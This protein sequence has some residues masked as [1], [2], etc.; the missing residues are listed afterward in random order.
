MQAYLCAFSIAVVFTV[1][2][3]LTVYNWTLFTCR[4]AIKII[5][6]SLFIIVIIIIIII[7]NNEIILYSAESVHEYILQHI[8][9]IYFI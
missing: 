7:I 6:T 1:R 4:S 3:R 5:N 9:F 8:T 2:Y